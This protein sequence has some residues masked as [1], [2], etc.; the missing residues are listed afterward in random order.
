M[1]APAFDRRS[2]TIGVVAL[3]LVQFCIGYE[4]L[5]SGLTKVVSGD[6]VDG[7]AAQLRSM[8]DA[9][10]WY[11]SFL[12]HGAIPPNDPRLL[13]RAVLGLYNSIWTW[14]RPHGIVELERVGVEYVEPRGE[15]VERQ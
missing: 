13:A 1:G 4:W 2:G 11:G 10:G 3:L 7:L 8:D 5:V 9:P 14:Y 12:Q 6:F 15:L